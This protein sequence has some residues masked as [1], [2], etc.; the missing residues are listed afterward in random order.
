MFSNSGGGVGLRCRRGVAA[1]WRAGWLAVVVAMLL[2]AAAVAQQGPARA[3]APEQPMPGEA[4]LRVTPLERL[5]EDR[6][7]L[8]LTAAQVARIEAIRTR[9][10]ARNAPLVHR[11]VVLRTAWHNERAA[12]RE[13]GRQHSP[14]LQQLRQRSEPVLRQIQDNNRLAMGAASQVLTTEQRQR[15]RDRI[16]ARRPPGLHEW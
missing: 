15:L 13:A 8:G 14:R 4:E 3:P 1:A 5:L 11:L 6:D 12:L 16:Q 2:P 9:V 7:A 10:E